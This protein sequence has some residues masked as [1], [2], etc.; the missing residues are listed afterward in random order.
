MGDLVEYWPKVLEA[1]GWLVLKE[2]PQV[3]GNLERECAL[4]LFQSSY[5]IREHVLDDDL[6]V[7]VSKV[8]N[9]DTFLGSSR[10]PA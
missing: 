6:D 2:L 8:R 5:H 4:I 1:D 7:L 3:L 10:P 9:I